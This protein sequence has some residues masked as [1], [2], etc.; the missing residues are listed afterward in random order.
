[1]QVS[2]ALC[3]KLASGAPRFLVAR[4]HNNLFYIATIDC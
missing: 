4:F 1:M 3:V 2:F